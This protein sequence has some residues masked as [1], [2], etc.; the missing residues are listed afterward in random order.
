MSLHYCPVQ[1]CFFRQNPPDSAW[2]LSEAEMAVIEPALEAGYIPRFEDGQWVIY[3]PDA[4]P[5][6]TRVRILRRQRQER[7]SASDWTQMPDSPLAPEQIAQWAA[8]RSALRE[9][10]QTYPDALDVIWPTPPST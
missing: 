7:L 9:L 1:M 2:E 6:D 4:P 10:P 5:L 8:Y 3:T